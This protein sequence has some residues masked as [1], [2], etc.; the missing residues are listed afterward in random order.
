MEEEIDVPKADEEDNQTTKTPPKP[1]KTSRSDKINQSTDLCIPHKWGRLLSLHPALP[2][3]DLVAE[4]LT[5]GR[6]RDSDLVLK[7]PTVSSRHCKISLDSVSKQVF[8]EDLSSN[9]TFVNGL[10]APKGK[11]VAIKNHDRISFVVSGG[12]TYLFE[13]LSSSNKMGKELLDNDESGIDRDYTIYEKLGEGAFSTVRMAVH[14]RT[15]ARQAIKIIDLSKHPNPRAQQHIQREIT[16]LMSID[17]PNV[18]KIVD[19]YLGKRSKVFLVME[20]AEGGE[21]FDKIAQEGACSEDEA[22]FIFCQLLDALHFLHKRGIT[23]RDL[24]PENILL[25]SM[26]PYPQVMI[27]DFG[28]ARILEGNELAQTQCGTPQYV[29]PEILLLSNAFSAPCAGTG[30]ASAGGALGYGKE[31]DMWS[32]GGI[33]YVLLS[34]V[35]PF[36]EHDTVTGLNLTSRIEK[37][38]FDFPYELWSGV[39]D[40]ATDLVTRLLTVDRV[41][42]YTTEQAMAHPWILAGLPGKVPT[43]PAPSVATSKT[44]PSSRT[45]SI[46]KSTPSKPSSTSSS[47]SSSSI[48]SSSSLSSRTPIAQRTNS[49]PLS[50]SSSSHLLLRSPPPP[51]SSL[52]SS[53]PLLLHKSKSMA[54]KRALTSEDEP[55]NDENNNNNNNIM[56]HKKSRLMI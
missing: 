20:L 44:A 37:G 9:G 3:V 55:N 48:P 8:V 45:P 24:K 22:R 38:I 39:S 4:M 41:A 19:V 46:T 15:G 40:E 29:A 6:K 12:L 54:V 13:D 47:P 53:R 1:V 56:P 14:K 26:E 17:H 2:H 30:A 25:R 18:A 5:I 27:T 35:P 36:Q 52:S 23:H 32:L 51:S 43:S 33:L 7:E 31:C 10:R 49:T 50:P 11:P 42:R 16:I 21:L 34:G 28:L